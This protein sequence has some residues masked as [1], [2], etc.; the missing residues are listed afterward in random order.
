MSSLI[1]VTY[2]SDPTFFNR[3]NW[4]RMERRPLLFGRS[5]KRLPKSD[6]M[7]SSGWP[8]HRENREFGSYFFQTGKTQGILLWHRGKILR[9]REN[10]FLWHREKFRHRENIWLWLLK[11]KV[12]LFFKFQNFLASLRSA[13]VFTSNYYL[14]LLPHALSTILP[15]YLLFSWLY[16]CMIFISDKKRYLCVE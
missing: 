2:D 6:S 3:F 16:W 9:H 10:I 14:L 1:I 5:G 8:R 7:G 12:C 13:K 11:W 15:V 4:N